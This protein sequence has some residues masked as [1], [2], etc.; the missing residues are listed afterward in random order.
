[1]DCDKIYPI[2]KVLLDNIEHLIHRRIYEGPAFLP[3][4]DRYLVYWYGADW[5]A[6]R[7]HYFLTYAVDIASGR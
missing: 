2:L 7:I 3:R 5:H 1:V 6:S 4:E